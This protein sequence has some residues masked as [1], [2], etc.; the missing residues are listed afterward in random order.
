[1][2]G[3]QR[4]LPDGVR[5]NPT[6]ADSIAFDRLGAVSGG[7]SASLILASGSDRHVELRVG[8]AGAVEVRR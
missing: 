1:M 3:T 2:S 7:A 6:S 5:F 8:A 4:D